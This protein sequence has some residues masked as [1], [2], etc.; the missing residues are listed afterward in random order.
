MILTWQAVPSPPCNRCLA[1]FTK[2]TQTRNETPVK[3]FP[4]FCTILYSGENFP[5]TEYEQMYQSH[6]ENS[7]EL[8]HKWLAEPVCLGLASAKGNTQLSTKGH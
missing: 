6:S 3:E 1:R 2:I 4:F 5:A 8:R 7:K